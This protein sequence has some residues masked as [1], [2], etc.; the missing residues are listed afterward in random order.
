M[1]ASIEFISSPWF[2]AVCLGAS[3][4]LVCFAVGFSMTAPRAVLSDHAQLAPDPAP[5]LWRRVWWVV[6]WIAPL[7][8]RLMPTVW[9]IR[10]AGQLREAGL[11]LALSPSQYVAG[12]I[13][14]ASIAALLAASLLDQGVRSVW[15][16]V[17]VAC[18]WGLPAARLAEQVQTRR[19]R[20]KRDLPIMLDLISLAVQ[21]GSTTP[22]A[23]ALAAERGP[24]GP[25]RDELA[26]VMRE[27]KAGRSRQDALRAM[28]ERFDLAGLRHAVAAIVTAERQGADLSPVL[29]AQA[30]Q[31]REERFLDAERRAMQAP[32]KLLLPLVAFIFPGTF[33]ILL[34]PVAMQ[35]LADGLF[36]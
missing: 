14:F 25:M 29:R 20:I 31:R 7:C 26:R 19:R 2:L 11:E 6:E 8:R 12:R 27:I 15:F 5:L 32:V 22:L 3:I 13:L 34:F 30:D 1:G 17:A 23:L 33:L 9:Q 10:L 28:G 18:G 24:A 16:V 4:A 35:L 36:S 21:A